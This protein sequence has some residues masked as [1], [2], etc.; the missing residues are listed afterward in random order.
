MELSMEQ[1]LE[2]ENDRKILEFRFSYKDTP[3]WPFVR[4]CALQSLQMNTLQ[5]PGKYRNSASAV[6]DSFLSK[7]GSGIVKNPFFSARK[8]DRKSVV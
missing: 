5:K 2:I 8:P 6:R 4:F 1:L 3:V 7:L